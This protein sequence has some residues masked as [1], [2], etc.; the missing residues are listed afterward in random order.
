MLPVS[1][2]AYIFIATALSNAAL[3]AAVLARR[4]R[5]RTHRAFFVYAA[6]SAIWIGGFGALL[7]TRHLAFV[8]V[9]NA[10]GVIILF[11]AF[12]LSRAFLPLRNGL[13]ESAWLVWFGI[14]MAAALQP[15]L[16]IA[17]VRFTETA[18]IPTQ[19]PWFPLYALCFAGTAIAIGVRFFSAYRRSCGRERAQLQYLFFGIGAF[20]AIAIVCDVVL[21]ALG[22]F[23]LNFVGPL[24]SLVSIGATGYAIVRHQLL[25]I[26]IVIQR[27]VL[28][29]GALLIAIAG[30]SLALAGAAR[31]L[32]RLAGFDVLYTKTIAI[33]LGVLAAPWLDRAVRHA[34]DPWLFQRAYDYANALEQLSR[35]LA[36]HASPDERIPEALSRITRLLRPRWIRYRDHASGAVFSDKGRLA[37]ATEVSPDYALRV[38]VRI[39]GRVAGEFMLGPRRS[40]HPYSRDDRALLRTLSLQLAGRI[41]EREPQGAEEIQRSLD[42][43]SH[44]LQTP[45]TVLKSALDTVRRADTPV[46]A[47]A[48]RDMERSIDVM[49]R[50]IRTMLELARP[51]APAGSAQDLIDAATV[52]E[53]TAEFARIVAETQDIRLDLSA[54]APAFIVASEKDIEEIA[55]NLLSNAIRY[56]A[57]CPVREIRVGVRQVAA[58]VTITVSDTG[59]GIEP[60][61]IPHLCTRFY[62]AHEDPA[63]PG[64]GLGLA[65]VDRLVK[66]HR[67][68]LH[69]ASE[70]GAG[71][72]V[73]VTFPRAQSGR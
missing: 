62:R 68:S 37:E 19:G 66:R 2:V 38:P 69:I 59:I 55:T 49:T 17:A 15:D 25:D 63:R 3:G 28:F 43:L 12:L 27:S 10:G 1:V 14:G 61:H 70:P 30:F 64:T 32:Y 46:R 72:T 9:L 45:L 34:T 39:Q 54:H 51:N 42:D 41:G 7:L 18:A 53:R 58:G 23:S 67:G 56:T 16:I 50:I 65:I 6:G 60:K 31:M 11:G 48:Y 40:G 5:G 20:M 29:F 44:A 26:R 73:R 24:A 22:V 57:G 13:A 4:P 33:A 71:T 36:R 35:A 8:P 47:E 21:P 52:I